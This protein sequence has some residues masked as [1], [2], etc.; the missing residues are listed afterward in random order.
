[1]VNAYV[2][3]NYKL[4]FPLLCNGYLRINYDEPVTHPTAAVESS[5]VL[6][7][8]AKN[9]NAGDTIAVDTIDAT[10]KFAIGDTVYDD[11]GASVGVVEAITS[12]LI[13]LVANNSVALTNN[14]NLKKNITTTKT[15]RDRPLWNHKDSFTL[16]AII[17]PYDVNGSADRTVLS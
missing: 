12:T 3:N 2:G 13:T 11:T 6:V 4:T 16:E 1:M 17:T 14:E 5:G 15:L 8:G 7:N 9:A 10:I